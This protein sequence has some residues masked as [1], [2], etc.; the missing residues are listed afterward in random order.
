MVMTAQ[1]SYHG[2]D[3]SVAFDRPVI[4][5]RGYLAKGP[6]GWLEIFP[7]KVADKALAEFVAPLDLGEVLETFATSMKLTYANG[8]K[9]EENW[10]DVT[11]YL[12]ALTQQ[13][14]KRIPEIVGVAFWAQL[15]LHDEHRETN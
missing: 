6:S 15:L 2:Q 8:R 1:K 14:P 7:R 5:P 4:G 12:G 3:R 13:D 10:K 9:R 11:S